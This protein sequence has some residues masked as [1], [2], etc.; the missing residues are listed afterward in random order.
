LR[1][2][3]LATTTAFGEGD[4]VR[5]LARLVNEFGA[6][7]VILGGHG[8]RGLKDLLYGTTANAL[9]HRVEASVLVIA[10]GRRSRR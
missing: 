4:P 8:H 2:I 1:E 5:E 3:G 9:R 6:D 7:L 10:L